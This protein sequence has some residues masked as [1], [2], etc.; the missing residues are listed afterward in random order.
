M[1]YSYDGAATWGETA[2][3]GAT[4]VNSVAV[5]STDK[6]TVYVA[7][8]NRVSRSRDCLRTWAN[9]YVDTRADATVTN[10]IV[11]FFNPAVVWASTSAGDLIR[12]SDNGSSW[13]VVK[14]FDGSIR[15]TLMASTDSRVIWVLVDGKSLWKTTDGGAS[16]TDLSATLAKFDGVFDTTTL[17]EDRATPNSV[18]LASRYGL[19][20]TVDGG[21]TWKSI[22]LLTPA[23]S[24]TI[25]SLVVNPK[26]SKELWYGTGNTLYHSVDGGSKWTTQRL[27][28]ARAATDLAI[29]P[30]NSGVLYLGATLI[31]TKK[32]F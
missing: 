3:L 31:Q 7:S 10:L 16:W 14:R 2:S 18:L 26:S 19:V 30:A 6:C 22:P 4:R 29:N 24:A 20:R 17:A 5:S 9:T 28:T 1:L 15:Q 13:S 23:G 27:P 32:L 25:F 11:D 8:G 21:A 12:S